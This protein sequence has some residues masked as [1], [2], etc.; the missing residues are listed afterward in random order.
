LI[1]I[2]DVYNMSDQF[3]PYMIRYAHLLM[4]SYGAGFGV[5]GFHG[6]DLKTF[7]IWLLE[8][9]SRGTYPLHNIYVKEPYVKYFQPHQPIWI[10]LWR[11]SMHTT[12]MGFD[13]DAVY[14]PYPSSYSF[15]KF[16]IISEMEDIMRGSNITD[17][18]LLTLLDKK[19][20]EIKGKIIL[21]MSKEEISYMKPYLCGGN[22][23]NIIPTLPSIMRRKIK[24]LLSGVCN[25]KK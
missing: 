3:A 22:I 19:I 12:P 15:Y 24:S 14:I 7:L 9:V 13:G 11:L 2:A 21:E 4:E 18:N 5:V 8:S 6:S 16:A 17:I 23:D 25:D 10:N 1:K 20:S